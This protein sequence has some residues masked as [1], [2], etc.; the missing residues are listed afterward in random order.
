MTSGSNVG[1]HADGERDGHRGWWAEGAGRYEQQRPVRTR[2][3][4]REAAAD[5]DAGA[6]QLKRGFAAT[7]E[8]QVSQRLLRPTRVLPPLVECNR[9][10]RAAGKMRRKYTLRR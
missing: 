9:A 1:R 3:R 4:T 5:V 10:F 6:D 2:S 7:E 8:A